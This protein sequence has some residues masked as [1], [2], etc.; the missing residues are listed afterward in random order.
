MSR[1]GR[2]SS[3]RGEEFARLQLE[4]DVLIRK[5]EV[6]AL[7]EE[8]SKVLKEMFAKEVTLL[9]NSSPDPYATSVPGVIY[10][11]VDGNLEVKVTKKMQILEF[12]VLSGRVY[13][14][15]TDLPE[16]GKILHENDGPT[17]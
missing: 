13:R 15:F 11:K 17:Q 14:P 2:E 9:H 4:K 1:I 7:F 5:R 16:L 10:L 3:R 6:S 8:A 12:F